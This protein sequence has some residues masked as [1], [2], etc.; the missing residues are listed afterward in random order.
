[1]TLSSLKLRR[2]ELDSRAMNQNKF[3]DET[4]TSRLEAAIELAGLTEQAVF[5]L[6]ARPSPSVRLPT[7]FAG[8][9]SALVKAFDNPPSLRSAGFDLKHGGNSRIVQGE[10][11]R[12]V[13]P[14]WKFWS[15]GVTVC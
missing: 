13:I 3:A 5:G 8:K 6:C 15:F 4:L 2:R 11:R 1:M 7:L 14:S 10:L 12:V 9:D